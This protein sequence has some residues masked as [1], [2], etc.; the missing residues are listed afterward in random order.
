MVRYIIPVGTEIERF[1][2][3]GDVRL[4]RQSGGAEKITTTKRA[5]YRDRDRGLDERFTD[6][7]I[8]FCLPDGCGYTFIR[9]PIESVLIEERN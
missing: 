8:R 7:Y 2:A 3:W 6:Q 4:I 1:T 9:V 5:V